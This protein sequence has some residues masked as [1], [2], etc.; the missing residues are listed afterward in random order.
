MPVELVTRT[1][2]MRFCQAR[3]ATPTPLLPM[4]PTT[5]ATQVPW[6]YTS[7]VLVLLSTKLYPAT[8]FPANS[9]WVDSTPLSTTATMTAVAPWV[10]SHAWGALTFVRC[11]CDPNDGSL[12]ETLDGTGR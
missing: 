9:G 4:A 5:P 2:M 1:G 7:A 12:G 11:H 10:T 3:P 8:S 6:P